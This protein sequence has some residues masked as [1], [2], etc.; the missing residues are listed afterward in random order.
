LAVVLA[1][2]LLATGCVNYAY[3]TGQAS[4]RPPDAIPDLETHRGRPVVLLVT[5]SMV[6]SRFY[7]VMKERLDQQGYLPVVY[8]PPDLFTESLKD[9]A[10]RVGKAVQTVLRVTGAQQLSIIAEC[11]GGIAT[12]YYVQRLGGHRYVDRFISFV[13]AHHGT[14]YFQMSWYPALGDIK[15]DSELMQEMSKLQPAAGQT[16]MFSIYLCNDE[17]MWPYTTSRIPGAMNIRVCDY[18]Y[19]QRAFAREAY[20][21]D[22][23]LGNSLVASYPIHLG[24]F[25]DEAFFELLLTAL[26]DDPSTVRQFRQLAIQVYDDRPP[27]ADPTGH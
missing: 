6:V 4:Y 12:R 22:H 14:S 18:G 3:R 16:T 9:G 17:I 11:N 2:C 23:F 26:R 19:Q 20:D 25:W 8:Q 1:G 10:A 24:G 13:S 7:D 15:R 27:P 21:V 5:G